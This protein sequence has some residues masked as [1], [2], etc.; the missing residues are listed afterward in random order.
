MVNLSV[1]L[2]PSLQLFGFESSALQYAA[3]VT[4]LVLF[5]VLRLVRR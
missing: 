3:L 4:L 1:A 5:A 2:L